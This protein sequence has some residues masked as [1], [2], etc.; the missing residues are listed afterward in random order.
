LRAN[1][2]EEFASRAL[3]LSRD[4]ELLLRMRKE[5][6]KNAES[7]TWDE[8]FGRVYS[9][10][11]ACFPDRARGGGSPRD[12]DWESAPLEARVPQLTY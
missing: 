2:V 10:Y 5:A 3:E 1:S 11:E 8:V 6:R 9:C 7:F 4:P 12:L